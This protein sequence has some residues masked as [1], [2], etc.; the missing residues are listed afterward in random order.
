MIG[1]IK[2]VLLL[3]VMMSFAVNVSAGEKSLHDEVTGQ[4]YGTAGCGLGSV[5]FGKKTGMVQVIASTTNY[6]SWNQTFGISS[7]TSNCQQESGKHASNLDKYIEANQGALANDVSRGNGQTLAGL[8]EIL[9][10]SDSAV[11]GTTLQKNYT[12]VFP[13]QNVDALSV[14]QSI[15]TTVR[16][17]Q[18]LATTCHGVS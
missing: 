6:T 12:R 4:G 3:A 14:S 7:G 2:V 11:L 5:V 18:A 10:C 8:S 15:Q 13:S 9:G 16:T 1:K 17:N